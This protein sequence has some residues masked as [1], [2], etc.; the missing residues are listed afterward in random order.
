MNQTIFYTIIVGI[1]LQE[2]KNVNDSFN[3]LCA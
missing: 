2:A 3:I 1:K